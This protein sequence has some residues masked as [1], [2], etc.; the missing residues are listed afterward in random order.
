MVKQGTGDDVCL[1]L[2]AGTDKLIGIVVHSHAYE[3][4]IELGDSGL[5]PKVT[6]GVLARGKIWVD[7][8]EAVAVTDAVR[9][10]VSDTGHVAGKFGKTADAGKSLDISKFARWLTSTT[11]AGIAQVEVDM[12]GRS[13]ATA[14]A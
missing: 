2:S 12:T 7:V 14:D 13:Q 6:V 8:E 9:V 3:K 5:K 11:G 4:D 10:F 1:R